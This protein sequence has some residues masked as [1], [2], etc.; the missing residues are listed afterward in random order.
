MGTRKEIVCRWITLTLIN[1]SVFVALV[2][3]VSVL[4]A[5]VVVVVEVVVAVTVV[6]VVMVVVVVI[7]VVAIAT[8]SLL[9][10]SLEIVDQPPME[11]LVH[12]ILLAQCKNH[13]PFLIR[14][15]LSQAL[16]RLAILAILGVFVSTHAIVAGAYFLFFTGG[17]GLLT[18]GISY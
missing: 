17:D 6:V 13:V 3:V 7:G 18:G 1:L 11:S 5:L 4:I 16:V 10:S 9:T 2:V 14:A 12:A 8:V 15:N